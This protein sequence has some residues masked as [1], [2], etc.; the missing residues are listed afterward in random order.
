VLIAASSLRAQAPTKTARD[1]SYRAISFG[2]FAT[3]GVDWQIEA[4]ELGYVFRRA[5]GLAAISLSSRIG[6]F[7]DQSSY[8]SD[9]RGMVYAAALSARTRVLEIAQLGDEEHNSPIGVDLTIE[10]AGYVASGSPFAEGSRWAAV[11]LLPSLRIGPGAITLGPSL[12]LAGHRRQAAMRG[13]LALRG[14]AAL[15]RRRGGR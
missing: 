13:V 10:A 12:F 14:E 15:S 6:S 5:R 8:L 2:Y 1:S 11:S 7:V 9:S 3:L 4:L